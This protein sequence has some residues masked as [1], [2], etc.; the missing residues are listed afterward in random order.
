M[1]GKERWERETYRPFVDKTPELFR[2]RPPRDRATK[3]LSYLGDVTV[4]GRP[5]LRGR[6]L[7][8]ASQSPHWE[9]P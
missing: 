2:F 8:L 4:N 6:L 3:I 9:A 7:R 5:D 1:S